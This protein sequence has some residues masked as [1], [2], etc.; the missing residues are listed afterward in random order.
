M[1]KNKW[2]N[3]GDT[4]YKWRNDP[5]LILSL[6]SSCHFLLMEGFWRTCWYNSLIPHVQRFYLTIKLWIDIT[7]NFVPPKF[8][9]CKLGLDRYHIY[10]NVYIYIYTYF[11]I[12]KIANV[13][14]P[15]DDPSKSQKSLAFD[16]FPKSRKTDVCFR[17]KNSSPIR[18]MPWYDFIFPYGF[19]SKHINQ[20]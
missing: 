10:F 17:Q 20:M 2:G 4:L 19:T 3:W 7:C 8:S 16:P 1:G 11:Y 13:Q 18:S 15:S 6:F 12:Y 14:S 5:H 9:H